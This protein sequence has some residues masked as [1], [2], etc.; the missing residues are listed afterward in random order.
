MF[1]CLQIFK[2]SRFQ[3]FTFS[4]TQLFR[5]S[6]LI[7]SALQSK[8]LIVDRKCAPDIITGMQTSMSGIRINATKERERDGFLIPSVFMEAP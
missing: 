3:V 5:S 6:A 8:T 7:S 2:S 4:R 1:S